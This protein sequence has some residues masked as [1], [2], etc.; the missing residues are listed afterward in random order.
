M[1]LAILSHFYSEDLKQKE[2]KEV[3]VYSLVSIV[4]R[5]HTF[6]TRRKA[7]ADRG[8]LMAE[9]IKGMAGKASLG[10]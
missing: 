7:D 8:M 5:E 1:L 4:A 6:Q 9:D 3:K 10:Q 2:Q